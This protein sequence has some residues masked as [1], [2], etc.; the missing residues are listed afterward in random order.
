MESVSRPRCLGGEA[1]GVSGVMI[2]VRPT[3][4]TGRC[5]LGTATGADLDEVLMFKLGVDSGGGVDVGRIRGST[6]VAM[7]SITWRGDQQ[8]RTP[9]RNQMAKQEQLSRLHKGIARWKD[10]EA[11]WKWASRD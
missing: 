2:G 9:A 7:N 11:I 10:E 1:G 6:I 3:E 4:Q 8:T 5:L